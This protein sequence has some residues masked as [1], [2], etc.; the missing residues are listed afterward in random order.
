[1]FSGRK[2][3]GEHEKAAFQIDR[4]PMERFRLNVV[5]LQR[6]LLALTYE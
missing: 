4:P 1:M 5:Y 3:C 2:I 6:V